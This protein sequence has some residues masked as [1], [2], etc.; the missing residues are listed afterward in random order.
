M[1]IGNGLLATQFRQDFS[2]P[3]GWIIF[4]SGVS[5]SGT[6]YRGE[7]DRERGLLK[8]AIEIRKPIAYFSTCS[9][10]DQTLKKTQY[11]QHK[12]LMEEIV[13]S[14]KHHA[15]FRLPQVVGHTRNPHTLTNFIYNKITNGEPLQVWKQARR[16]LLDVSDIGAV[17]RF[18]LQK[19][20]E[21]NKTIELAAPT[22]ISVL[23][24]VAIF[25]EVLQKRARV[26]LIEGGSAYPVD[27]SQF[28][29]IAK[30][31][32][33]NCSSDYYPAIIQKYYGK[34]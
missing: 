3:K 11:V 31:L 2:D 32:G 7:F 12:S 18:F 16:N 20:A 22:N 34:P 27:S 8:E 13:R 5:N 15:I 30:H 25:E 17:V 9:I 23:N 24:L 6:T 21:P 33:L 14:T 19:S 26:Q 10:S 4:A 1:I 28:V 29:A